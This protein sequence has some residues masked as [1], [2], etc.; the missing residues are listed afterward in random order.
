MGQATY[1]CAEQEVITAGVA[2]DAVST[3]LCCGMHSYHGHP[4]VTALRPSAK[5][6]Q[7]IMLPELLNV[8]TQRVCKIFDV[9]QTKCMYK[10]CC[11]SHCSVSIYLVIKFLFQLCQ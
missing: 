7:S 1:T 6:V 2:I 4:L 8:A 9:N 3:P 5:A 10:T 11:A